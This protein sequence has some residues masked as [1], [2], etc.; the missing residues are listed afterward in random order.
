MT[1]QR[2]DPVQHAGELF[3]AGWHCAEA[4]LL[5]TAAH[6]GVSSPLVPRIATPLCAGLGRAGGPCGAL[7]GALLGLGLLNGR[8]APDMAAWEAV[9]PPAFDLVARFRERFGAIACPDLL[10]IDLNTAEGRRAY[11]MQEM[12]KNRCAL[13]VTGAMELL[14]AVL[15]RQVGEAPQKK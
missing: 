1:E 11:G 2:Q 9:R 13:Y 12:K 15:G 8:D 14:L 7:T 5:A 4:V 3:A 10:G 6:A